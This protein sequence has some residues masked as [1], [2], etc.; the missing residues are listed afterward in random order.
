MS[1]IT[2]ELLYDPKTL[3]K[4]LDALER[5]LKNLRKNSKRCGTKQCR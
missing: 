4:D 5:N 3:K 2:Q 1:D